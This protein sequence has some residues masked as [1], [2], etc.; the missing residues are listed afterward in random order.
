MENVR[1]YLL[2]VD[3]RGDEKLTVR[4]W[5][6]DSGNRRILV[7]DEGFKQH[8]YAIPKPGEAGRILKL[9]EGLDVEASIVERRFF[10]KPVEAVRVES[11]SPKTLDEALSRVSGCRWVDMVLEDDLRASTQ[12][13]LERGV[14]PCCWVEAECE[15]VNLEGFKVDRVYLATGSVKPTGRLDVP[16]ARILAFHFYPLTRLAEPNP[17]SDPVAVLTVASPDIGVEQFKL[18]EGESEVLRGF[19]EVIEKL[20]P[21]VIV[22]F[23][24][25]RFGWSYLERRA[26]ACG[27]KLTVGRD[28]SKPHTSVYGHVSIVGRVNLD[29]YDLA[30]DIYEVKSN[31]LEELAGYLGVRLPGSPIPVFKIAEYW[32]GEGKPEVLGWSRILAEAMLACADEALPLAF[33]LSSLVGLP[34]DH[35]LT[36]AVGFRVESHLMF[37]A[38]ERGELI[39]KRSEVGYTRYA[40]GMVL[41]PRPGLHEDILVLD[42]KSLYP[43]L[44]IKYNVSPDT[45]V[46]PGEPPPASGF[47]EAPEVAYRFRREPKGLYAEALRRLLEA[48]EE[49]RE[50]LKKVKPG[51]AEYRIL[52]ARQKAVKI[53]ANATYGYAGWTGARWYLRPVAEAAAAWGRAML[54]SLIDY[55]SKIGLKVIYG[56][57]DSVFVKYDRVKV[58]KLVKFF[59]ESYGLEVKPE[60]RYRRILFTE[61]KK[62]Y[63]GLTE[64]GRIDFVGFEAVRGDWSLLAKR[65]QEEVG[66][67][68]LKE[69]STVKALA[70]LR[71]YVE[72]T[73]RRS[74]PVE[75]FVVWKTLSKPIDEYKVRAPHVEAARKLS[76]KGVKLRPG[77]RVGYVIT[78]RPT[79]RLYEKAEPHLFVKPEDVDVEY[80]IENQIVPA[81]MRIL[82]VLGVK[83]EQITG[84]QKTLF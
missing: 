68:V 2:D 76:A 29:L 73:R 75:Y 56:D 43:S 53:V 14:K 47:Y 51:T 62:R 18:D 80:Y 28:G 74:L 15:P 54:K 5:G 44:M 55:A 3:S 40:G 22:G 36:A 39:P 1:F 78:E 24:S 45:Y 7:L 61:A 81:A 9:V 42:F 19:V 34:P 77:Y 23:E 70:I 6:V 48:R 84:R 63:V 13:M 59:E 8:F 72:K 31:T 58:D 66:E 52:D 67:A 33:Q 64:D 49:V 32:S 65:V 82:K 35:V 38:V 30:E 46:Q 57:T 69:G 4:L 20:D 21:D 79:R 12:W 71:S 26:E 83:K 60:V 10:G 11:G 41:K 25:N 17:E 27:V 50:R 37:E 16:E